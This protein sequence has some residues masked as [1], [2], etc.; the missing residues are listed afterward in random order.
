MIL[1]GQ[2]TP[3]THNQRAWPREKSH[4]WLDIFRNL[5]FPP[6]VHGHQMSLQV[7]IVTGLVPTTYSS[8]DSRRSIYLKAPYIVGWVSC[9]CKTRSDIKACCRNISRLSSEMVKASEVKSL[10]WLTCWSWD[11]MSLLYQK[12]T[13]VQLLLGFLQQLAGNHQSL[14]LTCTFVDLCDSCVTIVPLSRH[15]RHITHPTQNLDC[16]IWSAKNNILK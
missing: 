13:A 3:I 6:G 11:W 9:R 2:F 15:V 8:Y 4:S 12:V 10:S 5:V 14:D 7:H 1:K 16:L